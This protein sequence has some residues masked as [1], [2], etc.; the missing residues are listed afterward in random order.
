MYFDGPINLRSIILTDHVVISI[1]W[2]SQTI[3][4]PL[5]LCKLTEKIAL[6]MFNEVSETRFCT[7]VPSCNASSPA[8]VNAQ[9]SRC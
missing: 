1:Q 3:T 5:K 8:S 4:Y 7:E 9:T 2:H 6:I